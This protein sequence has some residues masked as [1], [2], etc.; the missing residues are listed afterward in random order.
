MQALETS[1]STPVHAGR[2]PRRRLQAAGVA[3]GSV[4]VVGALWCLVDTAPAQGAPRDACRVAKLL[5]VPEQGGPDADGAYPASR[6]YDLG[7]DV[8]F[9]KAA[10]R[11]DRTARERF[12]T[13]DGHTYQEQLVPIAASTGRAVARARGR[14]T[15]A[16]PDYPF[17][18]EVAVPRALPGDARAPDSAWVAVKFPPLLVAGTYVTTNSLYG[19][20]TMEVVL[21][22]ASQGCGCS[23]SI[24]P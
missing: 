3:A 14:Q 23:F 13:P 16:V 7:F 5:P 8:A 2:G 12:F 10:L 20:W 11:V 4:L 17:P 22:G 1:G 21:D 15:R 18:L 19:R 24:V 6:V 9:P